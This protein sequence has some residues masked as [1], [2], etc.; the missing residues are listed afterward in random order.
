MGSHIYLHCVKDI[1]AWNGQMQA[2]CFYCF[3]FIRL[4]QCH[5]LHVYQLETS[6]YILGFVQRY[7][8]QTI[9]NTD[10]LN[11]YNCA[12]ELKALLLMLTVAQLAFPAALV[13]F[14]NVLLMLSNLLVKFTCTSLKFK[15]RLFKLTYMLLKCE[16]ELH[17]KGCRYFNEVNMHILKIITCYLIK[18]MCFFKFIYMLF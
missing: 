17:I 16:G 1:F 15:R 13:M 4:Q 9:T 18:H 8:I 10:V 12:T 5:V 11:V 14:T 2:S 3:V 6:K 7:C